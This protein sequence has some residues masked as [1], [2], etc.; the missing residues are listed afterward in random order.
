MSFKKR[1]A[2]AMRMLL[3]MEHNCLMRMGSIRALAMHAY[4]ITCLV[5]KS[6]RMQK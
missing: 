6:T 2:S 4:Y 5:E 1:A 3:E